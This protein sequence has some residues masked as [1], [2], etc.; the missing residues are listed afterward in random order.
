MIDTRRLRV[1]KA[2]SDAIEG[3]S[4]VGGYQHDLAGKVIRGR[5][6]LT[7]EDGQVPIVAINEKPVF[8][9]N[10]TS[11]VSGDSLTKLE[12]LVQGFCAEDRK[13]PTDPAYALLG[14]VQQRLAL[15]KTRDDGFNILGFGVIITK[16]SIGQG[17]V[18]PPDGVVSDTAFFWLPVTLTFA[19]NHS[20]PIA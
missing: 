2:L 19:E 18:R 12:L 20:K 11:E 6:V 4:V 1:L 9:E 8:P 13:H 3:I 7:P 16:I 14:D 5:T 15:E 10:L 17:V